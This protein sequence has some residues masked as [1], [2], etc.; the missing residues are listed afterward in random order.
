M[1]LA[2]FDF[3]GTIAT[4]E[5]FRDFMYHAVEPRRLAR[6]RMLLAP[7]IAGYKVG[8]ISGVVAR[9]AIVKFGFTGV[10]LAIVERH[11]I[12][13]AQTALPPIIRTEAIE[14]IAWHKNRGDTVAVVSGAL[15]VYL[16]PWCRQQDIGLVA[17]SLEQRDGILTGYYRGHQCVRE[18]KVRRI[19]EAFDLP[20]Y[21]RIYAYGDTRDDL[22]FLALANE[23][24]YRWRPMP[25]VGRYLGS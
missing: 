16:R 25:V 4:R 1:N 11:G 14:R 6:G 17:S 8:L 24:Y 19:K 18:E 2:L 7:L 13:F 23:S 15:D 3:D 21:D 9:A 10:P 12:A 20:M 22:P 5:T